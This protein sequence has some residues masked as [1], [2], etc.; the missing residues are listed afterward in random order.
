MR[1][2]W[3]FDQAEDVAAITTRFVVEE[4]YPILNVVHYEDDHSRGIIL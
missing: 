2:E 4:G 3:S 1:K